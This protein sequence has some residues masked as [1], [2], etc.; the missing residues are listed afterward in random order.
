[1][2]AVTICSDLGAAP[3][4][5]KVCHSFPIYSPRSDGTRCH[6]LSFLY[7]LIMGFPGGSDGKKS[8]CNVGDLG[9][10]PGLGRSP[11][12]GKGYPLQ[13]PC[14]KTPWTKGRQDWATFT[15]SL[16][17]THY[18]QVQT[19]LHALS[20]FTFRQPWL[21]YRRGKGLQML[22]HA[23]TVLVISGERGLEPN[24]SNFKT[25]KLGC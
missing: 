20:H 9:S 13:Y 25:R 5:N 8:T 21:F 6:D 12:G 3:H 11:G 19:T 4:P 17:E 23:P 18:G 7:I 16:L 1:M 24:L 2:A 10:I 15:H 22:D 14:L